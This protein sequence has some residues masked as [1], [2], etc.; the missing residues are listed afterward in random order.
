MSLIDFRGL[1]LRDV[2][3]LGLRDIS[4]GRSGAGLG[5]SMG[6]IKVKRLPGLV[7]F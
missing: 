3:G 6:N 2:S 5:V 7:C 4:R 1:V